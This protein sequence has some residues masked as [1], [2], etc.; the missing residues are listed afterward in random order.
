MPAVLV[1]LVMLIARLATSE[2]VGAD[3]AKHLRF[4]QCKSLIVDIIDFWRC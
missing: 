3:S 4:R 2:Y 1:M